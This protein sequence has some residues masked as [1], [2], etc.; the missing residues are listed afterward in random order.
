MF[1]TS[2]PKKTIKQKDLQF[3]WKSASS[4]LVFGIV[5]LLI[6]SGFRIVW[7][8]S[9]SLLDHFSFVW[10]SSLPILLYFRLDFRLDIILDWDQTLDCV[11]QLILPVTPPP[12]QPAVYSYSPLCVLWK[13]TELFLGT[14]E[15]PYLVCPWLFYFWMILILTNL[16]SFGLNQMNSIIQRQN[17]VSCSFTISRQ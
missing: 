15:G 12:A 5:Q 8:S 7:D 16:L 9:L 11:L 17:W 2:C 10:F 3:L 1:F 13:G 14:K 4:L 6:L